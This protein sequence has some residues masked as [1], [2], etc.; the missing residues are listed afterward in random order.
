MVDVERRILSCRAIEALRSGVPNRDAVRALGCAQPTIKDRFH[1]MLQ[2]MVSHQTTG[3]QAKGLIVS[4]DFGTGKSHLLEYLHHQA[5]EANFVCSKI[6]ISKETPLHNP[7]KVLR[8]AVQTAVMPDRKGFGITEAASKLKGAKNDIRNDL[9]AW[10][11]GDSKLN[12]QFAATLQLL[13]QQP[14]INEVWDRLVSFWSGNPLSLRELRSYLREFRLLEMYKIEKAKLLE[15]A[16]QRFVFLPRLFQAAGYSGWALFFD[17]V[18]LIGRY[19]IISRAKSYAELA[20]WMGYWAE[21][22]YPGICTVIAITSRFES[23][24]LEPKNDLEIAGY[25][26]SEKYS[27]ELAK[28]AEQGMKIIQKERIPL[29]QPN[30]N[31]IPEIQEKVRSI[32]SVAY[33]WQPPLASYKPETKSAPI[34]QF[35]KGWI[36]EWDLLRLDSTYVPDIK[37][38]VVNQNLDESPDLEISSNNSERA[39]E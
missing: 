25:K 11:G 4:G 8:A 23:E 38:K 34:R 16:Y 36:T 3:K 27:K 24:V 28:H 15:L 37:S 21:Q 32:H 33:D 2:D 31:S 30:P 26:L 35:I 39:P 17:E 20:R 6:I 19:S 18:E 12:L 9:I 14:K 22:Q 13:L 1:G 7:Y 10:A 29:K 5:L